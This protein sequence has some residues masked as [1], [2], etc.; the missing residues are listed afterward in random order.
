MMEPDTVFLRRILQMTESDHYRSPLRCLQDIQ[1]QIMARLAALRE[2]APGTGKETKDHLDFKMLQE[3]VRGIAD[4]WMSSEQHHEGWVLI[5]EL[6]FKRLRVAD[7]IIN[8]EKSQSK[9]D[10]PK[11]NEIEKIRLD[12]LAAIDLVMPRFASYADIAA[13]LFRMANEYKLREV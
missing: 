8:L 9:S 7:R 1:N 11:S 5:P 13:I 3:A 4:D 6:K 10:D 12:V 2:Y